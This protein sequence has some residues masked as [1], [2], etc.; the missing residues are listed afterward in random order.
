[1]I[2]HNYRPHVNRR[3]VNWATLA[4]PPLVVSVASESEPVA[5]TPDYT[6]FL[7]ADLVDLAEERGLDSSGT[8]AE[9]IGRLSDG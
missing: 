9:I 7:K 2:H 1:M 6:T 8:K 5:E 4:H 3:H